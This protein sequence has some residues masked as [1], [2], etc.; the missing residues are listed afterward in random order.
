VAAAFLAPSLVVFLCFRH[1]TGAASLLLGFLDWPVVGA[2]KFVGLANYANLIKDSV[3]WIAL[4]NTAAYA[5]MTVPV[6]VPLAL[7]LALL[8]NQGLP[9]SRL[10][11]LA[12]FVP[13]LT[14]TAIV[15]VVWRGLYH[16]DGPVNAMLRAAHLPA[17]DWLT[18]PRFAL[19]AIAIMAI[20]KH[21]G[22]NI[23][24]FLAGLQTIPAELEEAAR[25]DGAGSVGVFRCVT[26]PLLRPAVLLVV[27]LTT[28][29]SF[30]VFDA[31]YVMTGGGPFYATTTVVFA[32]YQI[33]FV[34]SQLGY[35]AAVG[36]V[37]FMIILTVSLLQRRLLTVGED[38]L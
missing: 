26:L 20:W 7:A 12:F 25:L 17:P 30:Q 16:P 10:F 33:A 19:P 11:R 18:D 21:V 27:V 15:A 22:F 5:V 24:V 32:V 31:A 3:F 29:A 36:V 34:Q 23:L 28:I 2:P 6:D 13:F 14:S 35:A 37:L 4:Q 9:G 38:A 1:L 8:L